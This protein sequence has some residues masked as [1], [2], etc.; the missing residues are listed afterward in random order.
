MNRRYISWIDAGGFE[1]ITTLTP[2]G[3]ADTTFGEVVAASNAS[4]TT[5]HEG[6]VSTTGNGPAQTSLYAPAGEMVACSLIDSIGTSYRIMLPA[7]VSTLMT[8]DNNTVDILNPDFANLSLHAAGELVVPQSGLA[9]LS[10]VAG[11]L[12]RRAPNLR[13]SY[14]CDGCVPGDFTYLRRALEWRD[15][16]NNNTLTLL[17]GHDTISNTMADLQTLS[18]AIITAWCEG[19]LHI[20][21][22]GTPIETL[23][24]GVKDAA[25]LLFADADGNIGRVVIPAPNGS[26]FYADKKTI[27]PSATLT[28]NIIGAALTELIVPSSG[29]SFDHYVGGRLIRSRSVGDQ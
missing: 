28:A 4:W 8:V 6:G 29:N 5:W 3:T 2:F 13:E 26:M 14:R 15:A 23:Y 27:N 11:W 16:Y 20:Q 19:E 1:R 24:A 21:V 7:P 17:V 9:V 18:N 12:F 10:A 22:G 25:N